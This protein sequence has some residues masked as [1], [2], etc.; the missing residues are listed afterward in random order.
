MAARQTDL[1]SAG[2]LLFR[3]TPAGLEVFLAHPGGP[4]WKNRDV[5]AWTI[6]KGVIAA[7]E[8][9]IDA[10]K[11]EFL[12]ETG[13]EPPDTLLP[14]GSV[15]QKAGKRVFAWAAE[16]Q[17]EPELIRSN[18]ASSEWPRGSGRWISFPEVDRC[19]WFDLPTARAKI[20]PAQVTLLD[21]LE[22]LLA[23]TL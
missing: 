13:L 18:L 12:E 5:A 15:R 20:N 9:P 4:F 19:E 16:G 23:S 11:R 1:E 8:A 6:P 3:R 21:R 7:G 2:L 17:A 14:L 10:A 22:A